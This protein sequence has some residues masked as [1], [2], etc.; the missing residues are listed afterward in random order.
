MSEII[1]N[2]NECIVLSEKMLTLAEAEDWDEVTTLENEHQILLR[3][4]SVESETFNV[5]EAELIRIAMQRLMEINKT[6]EDICLKHKKIAVESLKK[7]HQ[8]SKAHKA[9]SE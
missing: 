6:L 1:K 2:L 9:Y 5:A 7:A 8:N 3:E 4:V